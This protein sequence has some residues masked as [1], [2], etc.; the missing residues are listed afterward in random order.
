MDSHQVSVQNNWLLL[1]R[2]ELQRLQTLAAASNDGTFDVQLTGMPPLSFKGVTQGPEGTLI[3]PW[4]TGPGLEG[5]QV[6]LAD[7]SSLCKAQAKASSPVMGCEQTRAVGSG[8]R[9]QYNWPARTGDKQT[10]LPSW[11]GGLVGAVCGCALLA[12]A[13]VAGRRAVLRRRRGALHD[14]LTHGLAPSTSPLVKS[15]DVSQQHDSTQGHAGSSDGRGGARLPEGVAAATGSEVTGGSATGSSGDASDRWQFLSQRIGKRI[16]RIHM[17]QLAVYSDQ[18]SE[19]DWGTDNGSA[20]AIGARQLS[21]TGSTGGGGSS[22]CPPV[23]GHHSSSSGALD[24]PIAGQPSQSLQASQGDMSA[25]WLDQNLRLIEPIGHGSFGT[26]FRGI[27]QDHT[28]VAVKLMQ[29]PE[30]TSPE[31]GKGPSTR[32]RMVVQEAAIAAAMAHPHVVT[33][34][35]VGLRPCHVQQS[36]SQQVPWPQAQAQMPGQQ[37]AGSSSA[38]DSGSRGAGGGPGEG[39]SQRKPVIWSLQIVMVSSMIDW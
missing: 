26:V 11:A 10:G 19:T 7:E 28:E 38:E 15:D 16:A 39:A 30:L 2:P 29:L 8:A 4:M 18:A 34:F 5:R 9:P 1:P 27:L 23:G 12:G 32:E 25:K 14:A 24:T 33:V 31:K 21:T 6:G 3:V 22:T 20:A 36:A 35:S 17:Q 13:A 37:G